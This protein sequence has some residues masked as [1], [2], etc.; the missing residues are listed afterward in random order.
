MK[1]ENKVFTPIHNSFMTVLK[2]MGVGMQ[3]RMK[4]RLAY[5][6]SR[7]K[8]MEPYKVKINFNLEKNLIERRNIATDVLTM[9]RWIVGI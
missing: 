8:D 4:E 6:F 9:G 2:S 7:R 1:Y 5:N 3:F